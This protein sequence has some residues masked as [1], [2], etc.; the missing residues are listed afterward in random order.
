M[1]GF[2]S[3]PKSAKKRSFFEIMPWPVKG[4]QLTVKG[5]DAKGL[6][7]FGGAGAKSGLERSG[8]VCVSLGGV[9]S[10]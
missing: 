3:F 10:F 4:L 9:D 1:I 2:D 6:P 5:A 7:V 8:C